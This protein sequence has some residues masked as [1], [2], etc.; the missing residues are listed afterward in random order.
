MMMSASKLATTA[1]EPFARYL[2]RKH[3]VAGVAKAAC[4][5]ASPVWWSVELGAELPR[6]PA[7]VLHCGRGIENQ[8]LCHAASHSHIRVRNERLGQRK[9]CSLQR[10]RDWD[11]AARLVRPAG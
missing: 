7:E 8:I 6:V 5:K 1:P 4:R 3:L 11:D 9:R 10:R 2:S